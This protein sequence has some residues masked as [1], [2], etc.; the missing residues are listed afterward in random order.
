MNYLLRSAAVAAVLVIALPAW[1]QTGVPSAVGPPT[2]DGIYAGS[3][4]SASGRGFSSGVGSNRSKCW[5]NAPAKMT[6]RG[7]YIPDRPDRQWAGDW[8]HEAWAVPLGPNTLAK[9]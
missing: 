6:I 7:G 4:T 2:F 9:Q 1:A 3:L 8:H 5:T